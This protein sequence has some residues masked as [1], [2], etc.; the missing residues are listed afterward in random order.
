MCAT[1]NS[2]NQSSFSIF[3]T[4]IVSSSLPTSNNICMIKKNFDTVIFDDIPNIYNVILASTYNCA[5]I[6]NLM[7]NNRNIL[8]GHKNISV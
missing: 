1:F 3:Q 5:F 2:F 8:T 4:L 7:T 6:Q